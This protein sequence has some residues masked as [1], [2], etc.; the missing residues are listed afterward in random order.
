MAPG[1]QDSRV[2]LLLPQQT[3]CVAWGKSLLFSEPQFP[4]LEKSWNLAY[5]L[6]VLSGLMVFIKWSEMLRWKAQE[7]DKRL[8]Y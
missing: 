5:R 7:E 3:A 1:S 8:Y 4:P 6:H 2:P